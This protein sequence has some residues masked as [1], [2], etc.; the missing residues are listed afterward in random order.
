[1]TMPASAAPGASSPGVT[2]SSADSLEDWETGWGN[3]LSLNT[4]EYQEGSASIELTDGGN[5]V[6]FML[7]LDPVDTGL[8]RDEAVLEFWYWVEDVSALG[9]GEGRVELTSSGGPDS[10]QYEWRMIDLIPNLNDGWNLVSLDLANAGVAGDPDLSAINFFRLFNFSPEPISVRIDDLRLRQ[11]PEPQARLMPVSLG[12]HDVPIAEY[13]VRDF[14]AHPDD[15]VDDTHALQ[16]AMNAAHANGGGTVFAPVGQFDIHGTL[17]VP[18]AVT[19]R[20]DWASPD[21]GG[22]GEG[23]VLAAYSGRGQG[24]GT[25]FLTTRSGSTIRDLSIWYPEQD[26]PT[27]VVAY[28]WTIQNADGRND[29]GYYGPNLTNLTFVNSYRGVNVAV[30]ARHFVRNVHGTFLDEGM[31]F[32]GIYDIGQVQHVHMGPRYWAEWPGGP[33]SED[34]AAHLRANAVGI[35]AYKYDW[36]YFS[37][38]SFDSYAAALRTARSEHGL[39]NGQVWDLTITNG[40]VGLDLVE[41]SPI[42]VVVT[43]A[44]IHTPGGIGVHASSGL[45]DPQTISLAQTTFEAPQGQPVLLEGDGSVVVTES[46][47]VSW[48]QHAVTAM[49]GTVQLTGNAFTAASPAVLLSDEV[50]SAAILGNEFA[51]DADAVTDETADTAD[52][53]IDTGTWA[54]ADLPSIPDLTDAAPPVDRYPDPGSDTVVLVTDHGARGNGA[55]DDTAAFQAALQDAGSAGGG[56]VY[57]P[58][59]RYRITQPL[60]VPDGVELRGSWEGPHHYGNAPRGTVLVAYASEG[61][62]SPALLDLADGAGVRGLSVFYP[63]Q[64]HVDPID[65]PVTISARG[66]DS[67]VVDVTLPNSRQGIEVTGQDVVVDYASGMG[68]DTFITH[69]GTG[70]YVANVLNSV[71]D[72]QDGEREYNSPPP[73]WWMQTPPSQATGLRM[74]GATAVT[75]VNNFSF[76]MADGLVLAGTSSDLLVLGHGVDNSERA[77]VATGS[78]S[79]LVLVNSELVAIDLSDDPGDKRYLDVS[80]DFTGSLQLHQTLAWAARGGSNLHGSG[81]VT[82]S[83]WISSEGAFDVTGGSLHLS[84]SYLHDDAPQVRLGPDAAQALVIA[85]VGNAQTFEV[86]GDD[87]DPHCAA[88][89][90]R[91]DHGDPGT[92]SLPQDGCSPDAPID[93]EPIDP[94]PTDPEPIDP[95]PTDRDGDASEAEGSGAGPTQAGPPS[96]RD[97]ESLPG[98]LAD[99]GASIAIAM[100]V[101]TLLVS[102]GLI[103][104]RRVGER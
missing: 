59:G 66:D 81:E 70:G 101:V 61:Q 22:I 57:A 51:T 12:S 3:V 27:N 48:D 5:E 99:S 18:A 17:D 19:L 72:W 46:E 40:A 53:Q 100:L 75:M 80:E 50:S 64:D 16:S 62:S 65:Y 13:D 10:D 77:I 68:L 32:D 82:V 103:V 85:N 98:A 26:D 96:T 97:G 74:D 104:R 34:V 33:A 76:G 47:F 86:S 93:P 38:L 24:D 83:Q 45:S 9:D 6:Q 20:G 2:L 79:G 21:E 91:K 39:A 29:N 41:A 92:G 36:F 58:A 35:T 56:T 95:E 88:W 14:G 49:A 87:G 55:H 28:P 60:Q 78:G 7:N 8:S 94:E 30:A 54:P 44:T 11:Q 90:V 42:G 52:V 63:F 89:N 84:A 23:T 15:G 25:A 1:M 31:A 67:W 37:T 102:V 4:D 69:S 43:D 71:G 73:D